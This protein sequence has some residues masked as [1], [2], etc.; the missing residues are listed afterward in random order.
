M[1]IFV[2]STLKDLRPERQGAV[3]VLRRAQ[4]VPWGME[5]FVS[6]TSKPLDAALRDLGLSDAGVLMLDHLRIGDQFQVRPHCFAS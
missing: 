4:F 3:D 5:L 1:R 6:E 2:G